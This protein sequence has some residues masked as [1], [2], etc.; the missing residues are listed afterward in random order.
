MTGTA[1]K[2]RTFTLTNSFHGSTARVRVPADAVTE[3]ASDYRPL[4]RVRISHAQYRRA[5]KALCGIE[6]CTC[7]GIARDRDCQPTN[8]DFDA[9]DFDVA[10]RPDSEE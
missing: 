9:C 8:G 7:G 1:R 4:L 10:V 3:D 6:G 2:H 5:D